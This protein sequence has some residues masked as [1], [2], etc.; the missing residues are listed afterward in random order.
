L[1][2]NRYGI[3]GSKES[4][5]KCKRKS[6]KNNERKKC[7]GKEI[8]KKIDCDSKENEEKRREADLKWTSVLWMA[9]D[10]ER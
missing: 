7:K 9:E 3:K 6:S 8:K 5:S 2:G 4:E 1:D 10:C